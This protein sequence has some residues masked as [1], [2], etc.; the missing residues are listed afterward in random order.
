MSVGV[1]K[2]FLFCK[3]LPDWLW[4]PT[5]LLFDGY[6]EPFDPG[7]KQLMRNVHHP[8]PY[9]KNNN[10]NNKLQMGRQSVAVVILHITYARTVEVD[11]SRFS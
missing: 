7:L 5:T 2:F 4:G 9:N 6:R 1:G 11:Y 10:N 8:P 3:M